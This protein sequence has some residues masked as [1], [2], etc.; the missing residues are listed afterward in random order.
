MMKTK[1]LWGKLFSGNTKN[2]EEQS[3]SQK[4]KTKNDLPLV[5]SEEEMDCVE[6]HIEKYFG[7][8]GEVFHEIVSPDI[9]VDIVIIPPSVE[10]NFH[11]LITMGMGARKMDIP[12]KFNTYHLERAE[13]LVTL[14]A[15][16]DIKSNDEKDYWPIRWL[17]ILARLPITDETWLGWGHSIPNGEPFAENTR[18]SGVV[19]QHPYVSGTEYCTCELP[20][21]ER[22]NFYQII[23]LYEEEMQFKIEHDTERLFKRF[24]K[25]FSHVVSVGRESFFGGVK[26]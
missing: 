3:P 16:W 11:T 23:P 8:F 9:H 25:G 19:L 15:D 14:P 22:I 10:R 26:N 1:K 4:Q 2:A 13:I 5:Y 21:D 17:K 12:Q 6:N 24:G 7:N 18:L 20:N